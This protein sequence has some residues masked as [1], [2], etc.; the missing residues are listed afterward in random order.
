ML[1]NFGKTFIINETLPA[2]ESYKGLET[3]SEA[4]MVLDSE[5]HCSDDESSR[6]PSI[7]SREVVN[8]DVPGVGTG[9]LH[10]LH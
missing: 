3:E 9:D 5:N 7:M 10:F 6:P 4:L 8:G 1:C 2:P